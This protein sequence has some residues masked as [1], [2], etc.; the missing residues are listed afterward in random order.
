MA[1]DLKN[2]YGGTGNFRV[3]IWTRNR[4]LKACEPDT[5]PDPLI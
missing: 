5:E 1:S 3:H 2:K 4:A